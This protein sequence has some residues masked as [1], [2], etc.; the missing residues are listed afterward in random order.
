[1]KSTVSGYAKLAAATCLASLI[2]PPAVNAQPSPT[3]ADE[4]ASEPLTFDEM[5]V[6][7]AKSYARIYG[8]GLGEAMRRVLVMHDV[9]EPAGSLSAEFAGQI[10]GLYFTHGNDFGL[11]MRLTGREKKASRRLVGSRALKEQRQAARQAEK[12]DRDAAKTARKAARRSALG[13]SD[14]EIALAESVSDQAVETTVQF[15]ADASADRET[16][17]R[18]VSE[19]T[20]DIQKR[21]RS[22]DSVGYDERR[23]SVVVTVVGASGT[24]DAAAQEAVA[25]MFSVPVTYQ[26]VPKHMGVTAAT[27]GTPNYTISGSPWC[28]NAFVGFD[29]ANRPGLFSASHCQWS[30]N[31]SIG[32]TYKD[33]NGTTTTLGIDF[34]LNDWTTHGDMLFLTL[35]SGL[36]PSNLFF[37]QKATAARQLTGRRSLATTEVKSGTIAGSTICFYGRTTGPV[38]GQSCGEVVAKGVVLALDPNE[39]M[40]KAGSGT[41]Y[42]V[43]VQGPSTTMKCQG[44]DSGA[45]WFALSIAWG[46]MSRCAENWVNGGADSYAYYTS[47][48][49][50]YA[51][52]YR[53]S[54]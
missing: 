3:T 51:K 49:A 44:G 25:A 36:A 7:D 4:A 26:Y 29:S 54:Y 46:T 43:A 34:N 14:S 35:A 13:I 12:L 20:P 21:I 39:P 38:S 22:V 2:V 50:A 53:L 32:M 5:L 31:S 19:K 1:M 18:A 16:L 6:L 33:T 17:M 41:S 42:Y 48:D 9:V 15:L 28:T 30:N 8:V 47:M 23:A 27:G 11:K 37:A 24:V 45:P 40:M 10:G 52:G